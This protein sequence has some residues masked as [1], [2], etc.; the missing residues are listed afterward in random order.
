MITHAG[1]IPL[2]TNNTLLFVKNKKGKYV[3]PK[4]KIEDNETTQVTAKREAL[5]EAGIVVTIVKDIC[6]FKNTKWFLGNVEYIKKVY[7]EQDKRKRI[8]KNKDELDDLDTSKTTKFLIDYI[9]DNH[10]IHGMFL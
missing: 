7:K 2:V 9:R 10:V 6:T 3:F 1:I 5:E 4:G 8:I